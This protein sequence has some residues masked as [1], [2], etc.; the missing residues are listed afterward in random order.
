L[1]CF[2]AELRL[3]VSEPASQGGA[4]VP[5][6]Q[7]LIATPPP[8]RALRTVAGARLAL[9]RLYHQ[10]ASGAVD[11][12]V[13]GKL[14]HILNVLISSARDHQFAERLDALEASLTKQGDKPNGQSHRAAHYDRDRAW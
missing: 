4:L 7:E 6:L 9:A 11:P 2:E 14:T 5:K 1:L 3:Q 8:P 10:T 12:Q 13:A